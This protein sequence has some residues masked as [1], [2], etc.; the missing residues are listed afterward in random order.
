MFTRAASLPYGKG[1][2]F[3]LSRGFPASLNMKAAFA[4]FISHHNDTTISS[5]AF[6][7]SV[8]LRHWSRLET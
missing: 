1:Q 6:F 2:V 5:Y 3:T 7:V 8:S 4:F